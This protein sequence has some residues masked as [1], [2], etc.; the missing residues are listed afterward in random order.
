MVTWNRRAYFERTIANL[1]SDTS[2]FDLYFWDNGSV[3]GVRDI[4]ADLRDDR[5]AAK[6]YNSE[7]VGQF[8]AWHWF[9]ENCRG[10]VA[11]K[12]DDDI[13]G[14]KG[15]MARF[16]AIIG[17]FEGIG[18]LGAWV[19]L[20]S[21]WDETIARHKIIQVG[22]HSIF[23]NVW[24]AGSIFLGRL[25]LLRRYSSK[26]PA[27]LGVPLQYAQMTKAGLI[28]GYVLPLSIAENLDDPRSPHCRM[29]RP[30]GWDE[31]AAYSARM[32]NFSGPEEY[33]RWIAADARKVLEMSI[34]DQLRI[35][36]PTYADRFKSKISRGFTKVRNLTAR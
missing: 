23:Q 6:H 25:N 8:P 30:G 29:N 24:V 31:F 10:S 34:S 20:P 2:D 4:I 7:N 17:E 11:G 3:D 22:P 26:D 21:E 12:L 13:L 5:I 28:N 18:V 15:W 14:E 36:F 35:W 32:R 19:Y 27:N 9:L 16:A 1:L 33:G